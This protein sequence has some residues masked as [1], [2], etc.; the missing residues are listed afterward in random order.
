[1]THRERRQLRIA[2]ALAPDVVFRALVL[3][4]EDL[5]AFPKISKSKR[6]R[7]G[8]ARRDAGDAGTLNPLSRAGGVLVQRFHCEHG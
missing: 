1:M 7:A 5:V 8:G 3:A 6:R 4:R 2:T